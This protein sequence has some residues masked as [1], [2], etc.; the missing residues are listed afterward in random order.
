MTPFGPGNVALAPQVK[1]GAVAAP[2]IQGVG[3]TRDFRQVT[4]NTHSNLPLGIL[5]HF[6]RGAGFMRS[7]DIHGSDQHVSAIGATIGR[8]RGVVTA[9]GVAG[10]HQWGGAPVS[11]FSGFLR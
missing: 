3:L 8:A 5:S 11:L 1:L 2:S 4:N 6:R 10:G 9:L 7:E